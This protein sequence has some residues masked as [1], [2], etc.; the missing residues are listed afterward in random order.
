MRKVIPVILLLTACS[1]G[2]GPAQT[3]TSTNNPGTSL[4]VKGL[5][6]L[7]ASTLRERDVIPQ[8]A[9]N[10]GVDE[11]A[12]CECGLRRV[13]TKL[14][15]NPA[16]ILD[17]LRSTDAQVALLVQVGGECSAELLQRAITGQPYPGST[18]TPYPGTSPTPFPGSTPNPTPTFWPP[19]GE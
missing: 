13:E 12:V 14:S 4:I 16:L 17:L 2:A 3:G 9:R 5:T 7:C 18:P 8:Q 11:A 6:P 19:T 15:Q 10:L 1:T